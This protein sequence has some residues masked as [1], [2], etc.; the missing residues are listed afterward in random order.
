MNKLTK[1]IFSF[2]TLGV[3]LLIFNN[4]ENRNDPNSV[5]AAQASLA[6][7]IFSDLNNE[8]IVKVVYEVGATPYTGII[9]LS[10]NDTWDITKTSYQA[11]FQNHAGRVVTVPNLVGSF[12]QIPDQSKTTWT[13][14]ELLTLGASVSPADVVTNNKATVTVVF[15]NGLFEGNSGILGVHFSGRGFAFV[16][17]DVVASVGGTAADQRYVEQGTVVH[18]IGHV[19]GFVNNGVP[20]TSAYEDPAH[21]RHSSNTNCVMHWT[22]ESAT[23][24]LSFLTNN[25]LANR[26]NL[27]ENEVLSDGRAYHP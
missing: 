2:A 18:E 13:T 17:K 10:S 12:T 25:I 21:L 27:F 11:V 16:F 5:P 9:G 1:S 19:V 3:A 26:L 23:S 7:M 20:L 8:F 14:S 4:C 15:L 6:R 22:V 24:I